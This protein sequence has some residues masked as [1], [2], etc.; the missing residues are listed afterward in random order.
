MIEIALL[1]PLLLKNAIFSP[2]KDSLYESVEH[3]SLIAQATPFIAET[4]GFRFEL[5][6]C[7][8][9]QNVAEPYRCNF[10]VE[11]IGNRAREISINGD[12]APQ[13]TSYIVDSQGTTIPATSINVASD[14][15]TYYAGTNAQPS[16]PFRTSLFLEALPDGDVRFIELYCTALGGSRSQFSV[17]FLLDQ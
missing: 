5:A 12:V 10:L 1:A 13:R 8:V 2:T 7:S 17:K 16:V 11:N 6:G 15:Q 4:D 9:T 3:T 14:T